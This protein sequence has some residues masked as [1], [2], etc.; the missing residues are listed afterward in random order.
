MA[1]NLSRFEIVQMQMQ[2]KSPENQYY[3]ENMPYV[4]A[5]APPPLPDASSATPM[6]PQRLSVATTLAH[7]ENIYAVIEPEEKR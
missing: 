5:P 7:D 2:K 6:V 3:L 1:V 4:V